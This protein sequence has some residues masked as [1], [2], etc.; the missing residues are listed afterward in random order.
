MASQKPFH[1]GEYAV[2][3]IGGVWDAQTGVLLEHKQL[4]QVPFQAEIRASEPRMGVAGFAGFRLLYAF[5]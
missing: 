1:V 4:I 5:V 2:R 3:Q